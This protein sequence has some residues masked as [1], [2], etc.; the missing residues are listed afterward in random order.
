MPVE[1][2]IHKLLKWKP[3]NIRGV[4]PRV[5]HSESNMKSILLA[6][7]AYNPQAAAELDATI[8]DLRWVAV[9][10]RRRWTTQAELAALDLP[11]W[12]T[13]VKAT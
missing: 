4:K 9:L 8:A 13:E 11:G 6:V 10:A 3:W 7:R 12:L 2:L 5:T 1:K